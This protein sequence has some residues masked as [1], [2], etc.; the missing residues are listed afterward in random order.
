MRR[1]AEL[2]AAIDALGSLDPRR[3]RDRV[4]ARF[5]VPV[6]VRGYEAV[7]RAAADR[8]QLDREESN[9]SSAVA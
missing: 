6:M 5:D 1:P 3:C 4:E 7:Y 9:E 2:P 8:W